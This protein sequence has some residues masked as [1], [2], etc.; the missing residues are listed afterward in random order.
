[1]SKTYLCFNDESGSME[2]KKGDFYIRSSLV[3]NSEHLKTLENKINEIRNNLNLSN[4]NKEIKWQDLWQL[5]N[6]FKKSTKPKDNRLCEIYNYLCNLDKNYHLLI[7]YCEKVLKL[8]VDTN[9]DIRIILTFTDK[10]ECSNYG[11]KKIFK[12]HIQDHLQRLQMQFQSNDSIV[13]SLQM[14]FQSND[15]I[16]IIIFDSLNEENRKLFKEIHRSIIS[17]SDFIKKYTVV[18]DSL[19]FDDSYDNKFLQ[20][21]DFIAGCFAGTLTGIKKNQNDN[22]T[23]AIKFYRDYIFPTLCKTNNNEVWGAGMIE[24]PSNKEIREQYKN[25]ISKIINE[26]ILF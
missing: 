16:V 19:L 23:Y 26:Q 20:I 13:K 24:I 8:L 14:Q 5:Q 11:K 10:K 18:F 7:D 17:Q 1:M 15:S 3:V 25:K 12:F 2:D 6:C 22:Y 21:T 4:L 9:F